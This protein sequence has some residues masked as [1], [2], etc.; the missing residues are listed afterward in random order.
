MAARAAGGA[1]GSSLFLLEL[2]QGGRAL[3]TSGE[4]APA[5]QR[6]RTQSPPVLWSGPGNPEPETL[7]R[8]LGGSTTL[9]FLTKKTEAQEL[10]NKPGSHLAV[11]VAGDECML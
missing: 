11:A 8:S 2:V 7:S 4:G 3:S 5:L 10:D 9:L 1:A 6:N